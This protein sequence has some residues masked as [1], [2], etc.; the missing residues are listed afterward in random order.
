M[1]GRGNPFPILIFLFVMFMAFGGF[2]AVSGLSS[3]VWFVVFFVALGI[4]SRFLQRA[5]VSSS[6]T[7]QGQPTRTITSRRE[8]EYEAEREIREYTQRQARLTVP[9]EDEKR[10]VSPQTIADQALLRAG[11]RLDS[12][13]LALRDIGVLGFR[14]DAEPDVIRVEPVAAATTHIRPFAVIDLPY[15]QGQGPIR[16]MLYDETGEKRYDEVKEYTLSRGRNFIAAP[17]W[18][19]FDDE[20]P[21][22][23]WTLRISIGSK[24]LAVHEF[25]V[26]AASTETLVTRDHLTED[27]EIDPAVIRRLAGDSEADT[28]MSLDELLTEADA[29]TIGGVSNSLR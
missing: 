19:P 8:R 25:A 11:N 28:G 5:N 18:M 20:R 22:G 3:L 21:A 1:R 14:G 26:R 27:G 6:N 10:R 17:R 7:R 9:A 24:P 2:R 15:R 16:F 4:L 29:A 12:W 23:R 13:E